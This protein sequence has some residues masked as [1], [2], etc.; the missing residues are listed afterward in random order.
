METVTDYFLGFQNHCRWW[1]QPW[2]W[3]T[4]WKKSYDQNLDS[5]LKSRNTT[6][7]TKVQ[8]VQVMVS[9]SHIWMWELDHKESWALKNWCFW[10]VVLETTLESPLD[11]KEIHLVNPKGNQPWIFIGKTNAEA[12]TPILWPPDAKSWL[13]WKDPDAGKDWGQEKGPTE[14]EMVQCYY[15][16]DGHEFEQALGVGDRQG[17]LV[18][19]ST[20]GHIE[21]DTTEWLNCT[22]WQGQIQGSWWPP[23]SPAK[24]SS[25]S[26]LADI[27]NPVHGVWI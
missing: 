7:L 6:L 26:S 10:T 3:K 24:F 13:I 20:W 25:T 17:G 15:W 4:L 12:E 9:N 8:L 27:S 23:S 21:S 22:V 1:L 16:L 11:C 5:I 14:D 18:C 2:N 19:Y